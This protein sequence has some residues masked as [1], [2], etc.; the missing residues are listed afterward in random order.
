MSTC[1]TGCSITRRVC[2]SNRFKRQIVAANSFS[3]IMLKGF[4]C[5][6]Q[7]YGK[8]IMIVNL[9]KRRRKDAISSECFLFR[10]STLVG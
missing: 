6:S 9:M 3:S 8:E 10:E 4:I 2:L 1:L 5:Q 7:S